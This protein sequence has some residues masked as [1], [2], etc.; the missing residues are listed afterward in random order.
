[1]AKKYTEIRSGIEVTVADGVELPAAAYRPAGAA[2]PAS[3]DGPT[4]A[5]L[6]AQAASLGIEVPSK[7]TKAEI[8][9][10]VAGHAA[11]AAEASEELREAAP[12]GV[13]PG[14]ETGE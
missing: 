10:L 1:M 9:A 11:K 7:A 13:A 6:A 8:A 12:A 14:T 5:Q 4:K 2:G 3:V